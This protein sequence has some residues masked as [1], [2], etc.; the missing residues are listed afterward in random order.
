MA[1]IPRCVFCAQAAN[2]VLTRVADEK[3]IPACRRCVPKDLLLSWAYPDREPLATGA[4]ESERRGAK[5]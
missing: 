2:F 1:N 3:R 4:R 5:P